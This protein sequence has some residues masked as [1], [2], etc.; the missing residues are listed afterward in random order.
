M[1]SMQGRQEQ[2]IDPEEGPVALFA[3]ELRQL[4]EQCGRPTYRQLATWS[5]KVGC[6]YSDTTFSIAARGHTPPSHEVVLAFVRACLTYAKASEQQV[7]SAIVDWTLR[8]EVLER[9]IR[10][11]SP[12]PP[13]GDL[14]AAPEPG[15]SVTE[16]VAPAAEK[17]EA[18]HTREQLTPPSAPLP[19]PRP[20]GRRVR[21]MLAVI[22]GLA[23]CCG[24]LF[25]A[26]HIATP[27]SAVA[28]SGFEASPRTAQPSPDLGGNSRCG[29]LRYIDGVAWTA[30]TRNDGIRLAFAVHLINTGPDPVT[31]KAKLAYVRSARAQPC[32]GAWG[33]GMELTV[34]PGKAVTIPPTGCTATK[35]PATAFQA[36]AWVITPDA[37]SWGYREMSQSIHVQADGNTAIWADEA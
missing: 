15:R 28:E 36:K 14:P 21:R 37:S 6:P 30:C 22:A 33:I 19:F 26:R 5:A 35:V 16:S 1:V 13:S 27:G 31:L 34:A 17:A 20:S 2:P 25:V 4:R 11:G 8:W 3:I 29:R 10:T 18:D 23:A 7:A 9:E 24:L 32:P 12:A